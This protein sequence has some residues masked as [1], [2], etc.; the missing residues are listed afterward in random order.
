M[1]F[2]EIVTNWSLQHRG[3]M[4]HWTRLL[5]MTLVLGADT[6]MYTT[7]PSETTS[8]SAH[9]GGL[10]IG[11]LCGIIF[12]DNLE[13]TCW[14]RY[15]GGPLS[16]LLALLLP[17]ALGVYYYYLT[18]FPPDPLGNRFLKGTYDS[19][20]CCFSLLSCPKVPKETYG[21]AFYCTGVNGDELR[22][23]VT[24]LLLSGDT[25]AK[26]EAEAEGYL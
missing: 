10:A 12:L 16:F 1:H 2:A 6:Y 22:S 20:P 26:L 9:A 18:P 19:P 23:D 4:N 8:Y 13:T 7:A 24:E 3:L 5:V 17:L 25:C 11:F 14:H 21:T 15:V